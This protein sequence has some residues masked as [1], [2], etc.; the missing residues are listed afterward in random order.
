MNNF[1]YS[2]YYGRF[3]NET[4]EHATIMANWLQTVIGPHLP[5]DKQSSIIDIGC[6][7]GF[8]L[9]AMRNLGYQS[10][11]GLEMSPQQAERCRKAGFEVAVSDSTV[12]WLGR[13]RESFAFA[14]VLDVLEHVP[15]EV[16]INFMRAIYESLKPGGSV[17]LTVP[18]ANAILN[19]R[20]RY[21]DYTHY[22]SFTEHS[23][24][25]VLKNAG[26]KTI[27]L[28]ASK[29]LGKM[30]K[31]LWRKSSRDALRKWMVRWCWFQVF[32]AE[33]P[34]ERLQDISFEL[35][36]KAVATKA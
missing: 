1:D 34:W 9:R 7:Y 35:N 4:E 12:E 29:G 31:R 21:N 5:K 19:A 11:Q 3:H 26:F 13:N 24:Y 36:L 18:N 20:W 14:V 17:V 33:L 32:K 27:D 6:G 8:A 15:V 23:L 22:S 10:L 28:D 30:P 25:F 16:Q 2:I